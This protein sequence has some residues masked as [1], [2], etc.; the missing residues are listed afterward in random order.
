MT[1]FF[2]EDVE[3]E[4]PQDG[5]YVG[6]IHF[7]SPSDIMD[8]WGSKLTAEDHQRLSGY[9]QKTIDNAGATGQGGGSFKN[10]LNTGISK[11]QY[12]PFDGYYEYDMT[13]Q[14]QDAFDM[15]LGETTVVNEDGSTSKQ[16]LVFSMS[17]GSNTNM[18]YMQNN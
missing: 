12:V 15:P 14:L 1:T 9:Y 7:L 3:I 2:S 16:A 10:L 8:R 11:Q 13:L 17:K 18:V 6:R 4:F 5:E